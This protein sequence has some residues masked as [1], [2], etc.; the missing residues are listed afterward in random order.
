MPSH[1][2]IA[3]EDLILFLNAAFACSGQREFYHTADEQRVSVQ[4]LHAYILGNYRRLY[5]RTLA[6]GVNDFNAAEIIVNLLR[7]GRETPPDFRAEENALLGAALRRLPPQRSWKVLARLRRERVNNRRTRALVRAHMAGQRD[8]TFQAVKYRRFVRAAALHAHL[9]LGGEL[10]EFLFGTFRRAFRTPLLETY[11]QARYSAQAVYALPYSVA[12]GLAARH[13]IPP[14]ELAG[15]M[16]ARLTEG[17][18]LRVQRRSAAVVEV[19]PERLPLTALCLYVLGLPLTERQARA[20]ELEDW[21]GR[22]AQAVLHRAPLPLSPG[23]VAAVLDNSYS[24]S[25]SREKRRRP[26]ALALATDL[27]LRAGC[28]AGTYRAF[29][30]QPTASS[31]L[32][33]AAGQTNLTERL[34]DALNWGAQTVL[35]VSDGVENDPPGVFHAALRAARR[36]CPALKVLH[37]NPVFD[38]EMLT[39]RSLSPDLPAVG[40]RDADDLPTALGFAHFAAGGA[41]VSDLETYLLERVRAFLNPG[42]AHVDP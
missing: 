41:E 17:E 28:P 29:W 24:A 8:L 20:A 25:G 42:E 36:L 18:R 13:G 23:R 15:R 32:V 31:L 30:T 22:A 3:R 27:L 12:Q 1:D 9:H 19:R 38:A 26:L 37:V 35:V 33:Q 16:T 14:Q 5:A 10:P 34:L 21:L 11:R 40:L 7:T 39:V 6:A 4:F 2:T